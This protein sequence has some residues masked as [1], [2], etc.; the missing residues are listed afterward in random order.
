MI[1]RLAICFSRREVWE[2]CE[3]VVASKSK[4]GRGLNECGGVSIWI[5]SR[6]SIDNSRAGD[7]I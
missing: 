6:L 2:V 1:D 7:G 5:E 4:E 3:A